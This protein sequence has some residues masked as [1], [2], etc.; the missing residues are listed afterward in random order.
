[1]T[2]VMK[3]LNSFVYEEITSYKSE[4]ILSYSLWSPV[5]NI[6]MTKNTYHLLHSKYHNIV[7]LSE[8]N[9]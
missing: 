4:M 5:L 1:M 7:I 3:S 9:L 2:A 6:I 8:I